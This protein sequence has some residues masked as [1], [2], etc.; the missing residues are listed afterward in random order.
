MR[1]PIPLLRKPVLSGT[2][3]CLVIPTWCAWLVT[4]M[5]IDNG[6]RAEGATA[7]LE[8]GLVL[9]EEI[10]TSGCDNPT[11]S[12]PLRPQFHFTA[13]QNWLNDPNGLV[14]DGTRYHMFFQHNPLGTGWGNMTWGHATSPD[15]IHWTQHDHALLPYRTGDREGTIFSGSAIVDHNNSLGVQ[16]GEKKTLCAFFTYASQPKFYQAMAYSTDGGDTWTYWNEGR[17]VVENQ[18]ISDDERDPKVFW[19]EPSRRWVMVLWVQRNPGL[20]RFFASDDLVHWEHTSDLARDWAYECMDLVELPVD[21]DPNHIKSV[22][23]DASFDYEVGTFDGRQ[24]HTEFGPYQ[25]GGGNYYAAQS[26]NQNRDGRV[27]QIGW[28]RGGPN[29]A[30]TYDLPFNQ[31]MSFPYELSLR[32]I[33]SEVQ[34]F[35]WPIAEISSLVTEST[36]QREVALSDGENLLEGTAPFDLVDLEIEFDPGTAEKVVFQLSGAALCYDAQARTLVQRGVD[37][38]GQPQEVVVFA[39]LEP[40]D[41]L[42]KLRF[43]IDRLSVESF[44]FDGERFFA[45][46]YSPADNDASQ[47]IHAVGGDAHV[48]WIELRRLKSA[49]NSH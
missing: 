42:I 8:E 16:R 41:G 12:E 28:M 39:D 10:P 26:F 34:L 7:T 43:L 47:S 48:K 15:M 5:A 22:L 40:R 20:I 37:E 6:A 25:A 27:V 18:G 33:D 35:A 17:P 49:W 4:G 45:A 9:A 19:H 36:V 11:Y 21:G 30:D 31:Q 29:S 32:S 46:Y 24:F 14:Y 44:A 13:C 1:L 23:Y 38:H 2:V 3:C